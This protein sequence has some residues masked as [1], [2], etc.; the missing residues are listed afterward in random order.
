MI[1]TQKKAT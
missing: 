1:N